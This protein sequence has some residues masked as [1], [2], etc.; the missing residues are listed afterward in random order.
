[1]AYKKKWHKNTPDKLK[2]IGFECIVPYYQYQRKDG[3]ILK[4][5]TNVLW[6]ILNCDYMKKESTSLVEMYNY[7][8]ET[9]RKRATTCQK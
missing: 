3:V 8:E 7:I 6:A 4:K 2:D 1:M 9:E 5:I